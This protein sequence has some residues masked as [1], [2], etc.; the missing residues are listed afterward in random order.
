MNFTLT[1]HEKYEI[2]HLKTSELSGVHLCPFFVISY[3]TNLH[4]SAQHGCK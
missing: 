2:L 1:R 4:I 3:P